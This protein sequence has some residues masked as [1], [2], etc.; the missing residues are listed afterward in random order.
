MSSHHIIRENQE[1]ALLIVDIQAIN[2]ELLGQLLEWSPMLMTTDEYLDFF[3]ARSIKIDVV[4]ST[5]AIPQTTLQE[6]TVVI[7]SSQASL[8][9]DV[10]IYL[11]SKNQF[12]LHVLCN[13]AFFEQKLFNDERFTVVAFSNHIR[14]ISTT[15]FEKWLP[16]G[17]ILLL[18]D[19]DGIY[20]KERLIPT[21][22]NEYQVAEDGF[23]RISAWD[24]QKIRIGERL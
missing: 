10:S 2:E 4:F 14:Y 13:E 19:A 6:D 20:S 22:E 23:V 21:G 1:P 11:V 7:P 9:Q 8:Y 12:S 5:I 24:G 17:Q 3:L 16:K 18:D 15:I